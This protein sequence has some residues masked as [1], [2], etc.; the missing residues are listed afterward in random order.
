MD[1]S[2]MFYNNPYA[3]PWAAQ[4]IQQMPSQYGVNTSSG[5][6]AMSGLA[7]MIPVVGP[8]LGAGMNII[9]Q[10]MQNNKQEQFYNDY[11]SPQARMA[12]MR[13][14]GINPNAAAQGIAGASAPQMNAAAPTGA[15]S[16]IG[17]ALGQSANT[18]LTAE[19]LKAGID[20]TNAETDLTK[21]LNVEKQ[22][23]NK[24]LDSMQQQTL[25]NMVQDG[26]ISKHTAN[27]LA[28]DDY[29]HGAEAAAHLQQTFVAL[30]TMSKNLDVME[31]QIYETYS[32]A[33][34]EMMAGNLSEAQIHKVFSDIGLNNA[35]IAKIGHEIDNIDASTMATYQGM[36]ESRARTWLIREQ[37]RYQ[38]M[39]NDE[40]EETGYNRN[41]DVNSNLEIMIQKGDKAGAQEI[42]NG[43]AA[44]ITTQGNARFNS[45]D[46]NMDKAID[47]I[48]D[49]T[50]LIGMGMISGGMRRSGSTTTTYN[51][52]GN[53][54]GYTTT[55][56]YSY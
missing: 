52:K 13:A 24:Y 10:V 39:L 45:K 17:E 33:Y 6:S 34:A 37:A 54:T 7:S 4:N 5:L 25:N 55:D 31:A 32:Q 2:G 8:L 40:W 49:I 44:M 29:Y 35:Q 16:S 43:L 14:A 1:M 46:Y 11:M 9:G 22:T 20:K 47:L 42:L 15:F 48:G 27:M 53:P 38:G 3:N 23:T 19:S 12:Q 41:S 36:T 18:A 51:S 21:S 28:V 30:Q 56:S 26:R 50:R